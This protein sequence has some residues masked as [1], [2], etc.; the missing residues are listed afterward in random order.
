[1]IGK[2]ESKMSRTKPSSEKQII[3]ELSKPRKK[4]NKEGLRFK[5]LHERTGRAKST[6]S[7]QLSQLEKY[8]LVEK[9]DN[10][11][12]YLTEQPPQTELVVATL[13]KQGLTTVDEL[14]ED[15]EI[16]ESV[17]EPVLIRLEKKGVIQD[18]DQGFEVLGRGYGQF[19]YCPLCKN[20]VDNNGLVVR[21]RWNDK[22]G[23]FTVA[24]HPSCQKDNMAAW[25]SAAGLPDELH[26]FCDYCGLPLSPES[27]RNFPDAFAT[28]FDQEKHGEFDSWK[29]L[30]DPINQVYQQH[31]DMEDS[32]DVDMGSSPGQE[33]HEFFTHYNEDGKQYHPYCYEVKKR[34]E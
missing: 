4:S 3:A 8:G 33:S 14:V 12:Y 13:I 24:F 19:G 5:D 21:S 1:M 2:V 18:T 29:D 11:R 16:R 22:F 15:L 23:S 25:A 28:A 20:A 27:L 31:M 32:F 26:D 17:L 6:I 7:N 30:F 9:D 10:K 34:R